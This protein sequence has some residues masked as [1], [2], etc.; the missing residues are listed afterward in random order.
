MRRVDNSSA[1]MQVAKCEQQTVGV[2][3][4][5]GVKDSFVGVVPVV[6]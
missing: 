5:S 3:P 4:L 1:A 2:V 6:G